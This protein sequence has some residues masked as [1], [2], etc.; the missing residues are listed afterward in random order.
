MP[1]TSLIC[2]NFKVL[3]V[4]G[5]C[6]PCVNKKITK[7]RVIRDN[8]LIFLIDTFTSSYAH[9]HIEKDVYKL[10]KECKAGYVLP[11]EKCAEILA[12][13]FRCLKL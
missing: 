10:N 9:T 2:I 6:Y 5:K 13:S 4:K 3:E 8:M 7:A 12:F 11:T 1:L